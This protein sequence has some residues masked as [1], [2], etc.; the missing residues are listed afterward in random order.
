MCVTAV[1]MAVSTAVSA[2]GA[3]NQAKAQQHALRYKQQ[4][5][6]N[7]AIAARQNKA[8][9]A[10]RAEIAE[11]DHRRRIEGA[12]GTWRANVA[13]RGVLV[14]DADA[15]VDYELQNIAQFGEYD[16]AKMHDDAKLRMRTAEI[17]GMQFDAEG[18]LAGFE[19][20][21]INPMMDAGKV[22]LDGAGK[23]YGQGN[24]QGSYTSVYGKGG[25]GG[26]NPM[27]GS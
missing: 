1:I 17:Q 16:I 18:V 8:A 9:I 4:V 15:T 25:S 6:N 2:V 5:A 23:I 11:T 7:N 19:R 26:K 13:G 14:D 21:Q 12:K 24:A 20:D 27:F 10:E 22:L 3:Y